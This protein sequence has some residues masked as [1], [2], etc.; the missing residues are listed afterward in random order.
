MSPQASGRHREAARRDRRSRTRDGLVRDQPG[1]GGGAS[2]RAPPWPPSSIFCRA[3]RASWR[4]V[5]VG[6][7]TVS[8][9]VPKGT[10]KMSWSTKTTRSAALSR[11]NTTS[12]ASRTLSSSVTRSAGS[13]AGAPAATG[14]VCV[15]TNSISLESCARSRRERPDGSGQ[16]QAA[17]H[18]DQPAALVLDLARHGL[19]QPGK[20]VWTILG[21]AVSPAS[22]GQVDQ[23]GRCAFHA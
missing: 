12:K 17:G 3:R 1:L 22:E 23:Y 7:P 5:A 2:G 6:R 21:R 14:S 9:I 13:A 15:G 8:A 4:H 10:P 20:R 11:C 19:D 18:H 16:A